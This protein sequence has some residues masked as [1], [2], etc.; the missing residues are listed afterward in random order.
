LYQEAFDPPG[1]SIGASHAIGSSGIS[2]CD[3]EDSFWVLFGHRA[4]T[5]VPRA[6]GS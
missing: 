6:A 5:R 2:I 4:M 3:I 1:A